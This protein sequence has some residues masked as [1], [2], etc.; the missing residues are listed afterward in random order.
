MESKVTMLAVGQGAMNLIEIYDERGLV[1]LSL[2]DC[3]SEDRDSA[4]KDACKEALHYVSEKMKERFHQGDYVMLDNLLITH[5]DS[6]HWNLLDRLFEEAVGAKITFIDREGKIRYFLNETADGYKETYYLNTIEGNRSCLYEIKYCKEFE[7]GLSITYIESSPYISVELDYTYEE[8]YFYV[9]W[10]PEFI[11]MIVFDELLSSYDIEQQNKLPVYCN[12]KKFYITINNKKEEYDIPPNYEEFIFL[13]YEL[14]CYMKSDIMQIPD[15][16]DRVIKDLLDMGIPEK[17]DIYTILV[18][19]NKCHLPFIEKVYIGGNPYSYGTKFTEMMQAISMCT[20][21]DVVIKV[22]EGDDISLECGLKLHIIENLEVNQ[23]QKVIKAEAVTKASIRNNATSMVS[24]LLLD[25]NPGFKKIV[26]TGDATVHTFFQIL[27]KIDPEKP[28]EYCN[29]VWTAPH[30]GAYTTMRGLMYEFG[31]KVRT[32]VFPKALSL[33][34]P[35][36]MVVSAGVNNIYGHPCHS[37]ME[38]V[39]EFME[40]NEFQDMQHTVYWNQNDHN[41]KCGAEWELKP[42][43]IPLYTTYTTLQNGSVGYQNKTFSYP[44]EYDV[45]EENILLLENRIEPEGRIFGSKT[46]PVKEEIPSKSMFFHR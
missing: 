44:S 36:Q 26:F 38:W 31:Q 35:N 27:F 30:H 2:I 20:Q 22:K 14:Y 4:S 5:G 11:Y 7:I 15:E 8:K 29:A 6:D 10:D 24:V 21:N 42:V 46:I 37:F 33:M 3:G 41:R 19:N 13:F 1:N 25:Q 43:E 17:E 34:C 9:Q 40:C 12:D 32:E 18:Q 16:H 45:L 23:L 39:S 28:Y